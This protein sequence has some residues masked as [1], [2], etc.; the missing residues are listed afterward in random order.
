[1]PDLIRAAMS[2]RHKVLAH[3][4]GAYWKDIGRLDHYEAA[5]RDFEA[6]PARFLPS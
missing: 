1:M 2:Q 4:V 5:T 6:D 3:A